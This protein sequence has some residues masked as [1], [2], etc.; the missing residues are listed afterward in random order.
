MTSYLHT[1]VD[2]PISLR[3]SKRTR[4]FAVYRGTQQRQR[5]RLIHDRFP[6]P[7][8]HIFHPRPRWFPLPRCINVAF[9]SQR[10]TTL[11]APNVV[12]N[13]ARQSVSWN[14]DMRNVGDTSIS[15]GSLRNG[16]AVYIL[17][18]P[19]LYLAHPPRLR[20]NVAP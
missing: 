2:N 12:L 10:D 7:I 13:V 15:G 3:Y 11:F 18:L 8:F 16:A 5:V 6:H 20:H 14:T 4:I 1:H 17:A 9:I 19:R